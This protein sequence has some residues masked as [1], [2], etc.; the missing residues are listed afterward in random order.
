MKDQKINKLTDKKEKEERFE[1]KRLEAFQHFMS[2][3]LKEIYC[4]ECISNL[5]KKPILS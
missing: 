2:A 5:L 4:E 3:H 1:E